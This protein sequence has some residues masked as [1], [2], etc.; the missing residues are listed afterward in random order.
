MVAGLE[1]REQRAAGRRHAAGERDRVFGA[2]ERRDAPFELAHG[3]VAVAA[4]LFAFGIGIFAAH[5]ALERGGVLERVGRGLGDRRRQGVVGARSLDTGVHCVGRRGRFVFTLCHAA[6]L[7]AD[8]RSACC[9]SSQ[10]CVAARSSPTI[11]T[12]LGSRWL[13]AF[14]STPPFS[15]DFLATVSRQGTP[16]KSASLNFTPARSSRSSISPSS[17]SCSSSSSSRATA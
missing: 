12:C 1:Q 17:P 16:S 6:S 9:T 11:S 4:V 10:I 15:R 5:V 7:A 2:F 13:R 8:A 14:S 3:R